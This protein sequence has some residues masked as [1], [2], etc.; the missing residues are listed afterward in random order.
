MCDQ[1]TIEFCL[2]PYEIPQSWSYY[3]T[4]KYS[5]HLF[6]VI[7]SKYYHLVYVFEILPKSDKAVAK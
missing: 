7:Y 6:R 5:H 3:C 1:K 2:T 4:T